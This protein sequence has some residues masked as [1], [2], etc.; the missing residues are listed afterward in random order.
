MPEHKSSVSQTN[1]F[2]SVIFQLIALH[3]LLV[4][5]FRSNYG[6]RKAAA[7]TVTAAAM[8]PTVRFADR[9]VTP[10]APPVPGRRVHEA[11]GSTNEAKG[12]TKLK[13]LVKCR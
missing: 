12:S 4:S 8:R 9:G 6:G 11:K 13:F 5:I 7:D 1:A 2:P 3:N 10:I